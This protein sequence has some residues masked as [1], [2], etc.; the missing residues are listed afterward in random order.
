MNAAY[1]LYRGAIAN[2]LYQ[3]DYPAFPTD[4]LP[5]SPETAGQ[6]LTGNPDS[7]LS[8]FAQCIVRTNPAVVDS[9]LRTRPASDEEHDTLV[10]LSTDFSSCLFQGQTLQANALALRTALAT[11]AYTLSLAPPDR[12][13]SDS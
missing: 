3:R 9:L 6:F 12:S 5:T 13:A 11:A 2:A 10:T 4:R 8:D 1:S 7:L